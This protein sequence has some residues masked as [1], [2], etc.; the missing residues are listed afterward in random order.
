MFAEDASAENYKH[1]YLMLVETHKQESI[2]FQSRIMAI[3]ATSMVL[4]Q[5]VVPLC[6]NLISSYDPVYKSQFRAKH[7]VSS[8]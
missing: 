3:M 8:G 7:K 5:S 2:Q 6:L 4:I 1:W